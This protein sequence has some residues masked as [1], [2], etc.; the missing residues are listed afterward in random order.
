MQAAPGSAEHHCG[1]GPQP[2]LP[3]QGTWRKL[4]LSSGP[5]SSC[6]CGMNRKHTESQ[7]SYTA[8]GRLRDREKA[9]FF[10][11]LL[12][13]TEKTLLTSEVIFLVLQLADEHHS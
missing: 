1:Q 8:Q 7:K 2:A 9:A 10:V 13:G 12:A 6:S 4:W 3:M 5:I 11:V